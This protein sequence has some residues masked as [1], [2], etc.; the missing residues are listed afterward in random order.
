MTL[1]TSRRSVT[2]RS[3]F[4]MRGVDGVQPAGTYTVESEEELL[5]QLS[6]TAYRRVSTSIV[7]PLGGANSYQLLK[8]DPADLEAAELRDAQ[9]DVSGS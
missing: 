5:E 2:F 3:P 8:V 9:T 1:R 6:F 4:S 7:L